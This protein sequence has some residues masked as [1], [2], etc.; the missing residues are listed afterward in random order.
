MF[1]QEQ[2]IRESIAL[3]LNSTYQ[4]DLPENGILGA[5]LIKIEGNNYTGHG[6][7]AP[8]WRVLDNITKI[9]VILNGATICK[10]LRGDMIQATA[11]YDNGIVAPDLWRH[12]ATNSQ[13]GFFLLNFGRYLYD[14][15]VGLN[16]AKFANVELRITNDADATAEFSSLT[17]SIL[18]YFL[19]EG[20]AAGPIG[21][22]RTETWR[23]WT[24]VRA[25]TEYLDLPTEFP[26]R[27]IILQG[28]PALDG[29]HHVKRNFYHMMED[30]EL[31]LDT[32][33]TRVFKGGIDVLA[34]SNIYA[35]RH[36]I[37]TGGEVYGLDSDAIETGVGSMQK[38]AHGAT[39]ADL[40][41]DPT[42]PAGFQST[43]S[44]NTQNINTYPTDEP[45]RTLWSGC[46]YHNTAVLKFDWDQDPNSWLDPKS[47][48]SVEL[49][50]ITENNADA[51]GG[52]NRVILDR[53]VR[54]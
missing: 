45:I 37:L 46:G 35:Y 3:T 36:E 39:H 49:N 19:R 40:G 20:P 1:W 53:L 54:V 21:F 26:I 16:L 48:A 10:S 47:R 23:E 4:L 13:Y 28:R 50:I 17:V 43:D 25:A 22:M 8:E 5:L 14:P 34:K 30:I 41:T 31:S 24:T 32:G 51:A 18:G 42:V 33:V 7:D 12:Y 11:F 6:Q 29:G 44:A 9:E 38:S 15:L 27:R 52:T 2:Y